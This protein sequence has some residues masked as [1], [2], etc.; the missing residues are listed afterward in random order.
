MF[1][2]KCNANYCSKSVYLKV[3]CRGCALI[4]SCVTHSQGLCFVCRLLLQV[5]TE[6][7]AEEASMSFGCS[8]KSCR[9]LLEMAKELGVQVVGVT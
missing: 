1:V 2:N 4:G 8:L 5:S 9:H 3:K 6:P 7:N